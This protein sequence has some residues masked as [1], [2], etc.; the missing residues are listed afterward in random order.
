ML[1]DKPYTYRRVGSREQYERKIREQAEWVSWRILKDWVE[2]QMALVESG[3][4]E[5]A[6]VFMPY[7]TRQD[8]QTMWQAYL[9]AN[10]QLALGAGQ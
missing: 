9:C 1:K 2:A 3:Q 5:A 8:G 10:E 4:A 6:Q 7:A